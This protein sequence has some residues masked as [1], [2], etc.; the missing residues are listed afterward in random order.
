M[1]TRLSLLVLLLISLAAWLVFVALHPR[2][3]SYVI[4]GKLSVDD[5]SSVIGAVVYFT[6]EDRAP[7]RFDEL[8]KARVQPGG[9]FDTRFN[10]TPNR[11]VYLYACKQGYTT[12]RTAVMLSGPG[13]TIRLDE[14]L[15]ISSLPY[16]RPYNE[17]I[18]EQEALEVLAY[19]D[20]CLSRLKGRRPIQR[21]RFF[22]DYQ[23][24]PVNC[25]PG[26]PFE[27]CR[28]KLGID[29]RVSAR[30][31]YIAIQPAGNPVYIG[32]RD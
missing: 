29:G 25:G 10:G 4:K 6:Q 26:Q 1:T 30:H 18:E 27:V 9:F 17:F 2:A 22:E 15:L 16:S 31:S 19:E 8:H 32:K 5:R 7:D 11:P 13:A 3:A 23:K 24:L 20:E 28:A 12:V 21:V 14:P